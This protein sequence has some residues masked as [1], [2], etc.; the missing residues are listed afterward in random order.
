MISYTGLPT[1]DG[2]TETIVR[3]LF[4]PFSRFQGSLWLISVFR[5]LGN[6]QNTQ[7]NANPKNQASNCYIFRVLG[8]LYTINCCSYSFRGIIFR[9]ISHCF[10]LINL[11]EIWT[12]V[13][14]RWKLYSMCSN[15]REILS[16]KHRQ[17]K[18]AYDVTDYRGECDVAPYAE[19]IYLC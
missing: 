18:S 1:K 5:H 3:I 7:L 16:P 11:C 12:K 13:F 19:F 6:H 15:V 10:R 8:R 4:S 14:V 9:K 2:T 17:I